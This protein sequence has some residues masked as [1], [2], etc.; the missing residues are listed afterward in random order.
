MALVRSCPLCYKVVIG[1]SQHLRYIHHVRN[2]EERVLLCNWQSGLVNVR[3]EQCPVTGCSTHLSRLDWH[4][5]SHTELYRQVLEDLWRRLTMERLAAWR[6]S[7]P[8]FPLA[9]DLDI[10]ETKERRG[11]GNTMFTNRSRGGS[12]LQRGFCY[13]HAPILRLKKAVQERDEALTMRS[14]TNQSIKEDNL[15]LI[16]ELHRVRKKY[17][18]LK[19]KMGIVRVSPAKKALNFQAEADRHKATGS[20][21]QREEPTVSG[22][23]CKLIFPGSAMSVFIGGFRKTCEGPNPNYKLRENCASK[24]KRGMKFLNYMAKNET[25]QSSLLFLT[26]HDKIRQKTLA[27]FL[28]IPRRPLHLAAG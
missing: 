26:D 25:Y 20:G 10:V 5:D 3:Q 17:Q 7:I 18:L 21:D 9:T 19:R 12:G 15:K 4:I 1:F 22:S 11:G 13:C 23:S 24:V 16:D 2:S 8:A 14:E 28:N 6:A 27:H